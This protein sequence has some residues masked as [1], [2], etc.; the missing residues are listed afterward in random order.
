MKELREEDIKKRLINNN[1]LF[2]DLHIIKQKFDILP[3]KKE[4][5]GVSI[6]YQDIQELREDFIDDLLDTVVEWV[7]S[8]EKYKELV[9]K[10]IAGGKSEA[11]A[12]STI[13]RKARKKFRKGNDQNLL[14]QGQFGELLLFHF[15]QK[16]MGAVPLLRKMK[17]TTSSQHERFGADA[18]HYKIEENKNIIILGEAKTYSSKYGFNKAFEDAVTSILNTYKT[19]RNELKLYVHEDFLDQEMDDIAEAY[20]QKEL[21]NIE[22][23]LVCI[24]VYHET[25]RLKQTEETSIKKEI[26]KIIEDR[27]SNFD[28]KKIPI[29]DNYI[30]NRITY[31][32]FPVW[33]LDELLKVFQREL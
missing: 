6:A 19:H 5:Y 18:I 31:I 11:T 17:I 8:S 7:Y 1:A 33:K 14:V 30:L 15:I 3:D 16:C 25:E 22:I 12:S 10:E 20:L 26:E 29:E 9:K 2:K 4:H 32:V 21:K 13:Q 24:V 27:Y 28:N 23:H